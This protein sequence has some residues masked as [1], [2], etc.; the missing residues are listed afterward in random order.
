MPRLIVSYFYRDSLV[1]HRKT[2]VSAPHAYSMMHPS[3]PLAVVLVVLAMAAFASPSTPPSAPTHPSS[4]SS[5][6]AAPRPVWRAQDWRAA[7][8]LAGFTGAIRI[9]L[10]RR[11]LAMLENE[12]S[13]RAMQD[14]TVLPHYQLTE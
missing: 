12:M 10:E 3:H 13:M 11:K 4:P 1:G 8:G 6:G 5:T 7:I 2:L 9:T 14:A